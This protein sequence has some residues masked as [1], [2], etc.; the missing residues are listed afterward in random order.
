MNT[1]A[2]DL[3]FH[4]PRPGPRRRRAAH[5]GLI[6]S[7][8]WVLAACGTVP[9][10]PPAAAAPT[11]AAPPAPPPLPAPPPPPVL[12]V[13]PVQAPPAAPPVE[14][15]A[16]TPP[17][18]DVITAL[19]TYAE[20]LRVLN[21]T[22][23]AAEIVVQGDPGSVPLRQMQLAL[24]LVH[25]HQ[26]ADTARA[27]GLVQRVVGSPAPESLP[28]KPLA[29]LL[30]ARLMDQR[31]LE[32]TVDKQAQ[33]LRDSQRR[34]DQLNERLEAMRAIERSLNSRPSAAPPATAPAR[35]TAP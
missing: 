9:E 18:P 8:A 34:I 20:R 11:V 5:L 15:A 2:T 23:L 32:D 29:R 26:P 12:R 31:R 6:V 24:A 17:V 1:F 35:P 7:S 30:A 10:P 21:P 22:D 28:L 14:L 25:T 4:R 33:Q 27:L 16:E 3:L 13:T 19:L